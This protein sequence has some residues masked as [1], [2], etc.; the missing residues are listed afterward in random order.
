MS[1]ALVLALA[2]LGAMG[3]DGTLPARRRSGTPGAFGRRDK[4]APQRYFGGRSGRRLT[5][6]LRMQ[7]GHEP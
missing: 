1:R 5:R 7:N 6:R 3:F 4:P 2:T